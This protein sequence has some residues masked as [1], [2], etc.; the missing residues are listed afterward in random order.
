VLID[1]AA[2]LRRKFNALFVAFPGDED[3]FGGCLA[4]GRGFIHVSPSGSLEPCPFAPYSDRNILDMSLKRALR[5][6][7]LEKIRQNHDKLQE[8]AGGCALWTERE[9]VSSL[10]SENGSSEKAA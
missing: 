2:R 8:T 4:A 3:E 10:L 9:W 6:P 5:S 1:T 7:L